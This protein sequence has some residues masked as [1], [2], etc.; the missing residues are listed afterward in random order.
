[1]LGISRPLASLVH[2][3][4]RMAQGEI[5]AEIPEAAR[6]DEIGSVGKAI[7]GI[8]AMVAQKA[9]EQA[10][11]K[12]IADAAAAVERKRTMVELADGFEQA[13]G[14]IIGMV[15][16]SSTEL[17]ATAQTHDCKFGHRPS[18][19]GAHGNG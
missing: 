11:I 4:Q 18:Q 15:S 5:D 12:R 14:G 16:S 3:L 8:K 19:G 9:A 2:V 13:V 1:M 7:E 10:E 17:Q 6:S